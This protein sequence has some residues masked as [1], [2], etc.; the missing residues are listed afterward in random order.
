MMP[1]HLTESYI[2]KK[3]RIAWKQNGGTDIFN[4]ADPAQAIE[5]RC[6]AVLIP[7]TWFDDEWHLLY[8][9]RTD[10]VETHKGQVSFPGG[11]CD[12]G[13]E[14]PEQTALREAEEEIG[15]G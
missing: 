10:K 15:E 8:T 6:A 2:T 13:E 12:P 7:L 11:A 14:T 3:L 9:R 5:P 1:P 4:D